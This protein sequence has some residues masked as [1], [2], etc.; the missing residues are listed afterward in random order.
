MNHSPSQTRLLS[1]LLLVALAFSA[2]FRSSAKALE[3]S[4]SGSSPSQFISA[5]DNASR[6]HVLT[7]ASGQRVARVAAKP[8]KL[9]LP[10][11]QS[12]LMASRHNLQSVNPRLFFVADHSV[13]YDSVRAFSVGGRDPPST[14]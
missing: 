2:N 4:D 8:D 1:A 9:K 12:G 7:T 5:D 3:D 11:V 14:L 6:S 10:P 13:S